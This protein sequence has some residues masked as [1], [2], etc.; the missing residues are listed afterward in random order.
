MA[1][2]EQR[3]SDVFLMRLREMRR[4]RGWSQAE[5]AA[6]MTEAGRPMGRAALLRIENGERGLSLDEA[7]SFAAVLHVAPAHLLSPRGDGIVWLTSKLG[8]DG[9][10]MRAWLLHGDEFIATASDYHRGEHAKALER[11]VLAHAKALMDAQNGDD[12]AGMK[13]ELVALGSA[14]ANYRAAL[15]KRGFELGEEE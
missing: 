15:E 1:E 14:A 6:V 12:K 5:L 2:E 10:G 4:A 9:E 8:V 3:V 7:L 11:V 13:T